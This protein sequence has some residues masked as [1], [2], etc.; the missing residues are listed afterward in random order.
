MDVRV[1]AQE[2]VDASRL[3]R[4]EVVGD[5][6]NG[7]TRRLLHHEVGQEGDEL[8]RG[9]VGRRLAQ[10]CAGPGIESC[11]Q[12]EGA[13]PGVLE[14]MALSATRQVIVINHRLR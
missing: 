10:H 2:G 6:V 12:R 8:G 5:D 4:R 14:P 1:L 13:V 9:V 3:V 7:L 11:V